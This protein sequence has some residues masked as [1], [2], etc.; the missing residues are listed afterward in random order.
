MAKTHRGTG[1]KELVK[2]GRGECPE[3]KRTGVKLLYEI[4]E[5]E[6]KKNVCKECSKALKKKA[7]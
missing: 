5:G 7:K 6:S 3:C 4:Q 2:N 1:L